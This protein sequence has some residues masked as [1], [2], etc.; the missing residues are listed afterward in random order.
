MFFEKSQ[1]EYSLWMKVFKLIEEMNRRKIPVILVNPFDYENIVTLHE[2]QANEPVMIIP[3]MSKQGSDAR[4]AHMLK[5]LK[6]GLEP[7]ATNAPEK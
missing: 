6:T 1:I 7:E 5:G 3:S 2:R 4:F